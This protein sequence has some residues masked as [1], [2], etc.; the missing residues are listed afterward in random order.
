M[1]VQ[2][3]AHRLTARPPDGPRDFKLPPGL[4]SIEAGPGQEGMLYVPE[5]YSPL[6][7]PPL[8]VLCHGAGSEARAGI[9]PLLRLAD[10]AGMVLLAPD[11]RDDTWDLLL[12]GGGHDAAA[13][14]ALLE[15]VFEELPVDPR[16]VALGG[17]SDG[18]SYALSI[19]LANGD[20]F[21][22]L[23]AFSPG[24]VKPPARRGE[25][26][27]FMSHGREDRVL[28]ID[29]CSRVIAPMLRAAGL[30][31]VYEEFG[32][33][34]T[35]PPAVAC[36]AAQWFTDVRLAVPLHHEAPGEPGKAHAAP[37]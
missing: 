19:G 7:A 28:P 30:E 20:L 8:A 35:V 10:E 4:R 34:H 9:C 3:E 23:I 27:V 25:P 21:T 22:H 29:R 33:G 24:F 36:E 2:G 14:D 16:R 32:D 26:R 5:T 31:V 37:A 11:A 12:G 15:L 6:R 18:A 17:F 1:R 13:I